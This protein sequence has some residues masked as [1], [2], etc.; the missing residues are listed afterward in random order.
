MDW[1]EAFAVVTGIPPAGAQYANLSRQPQLFWQGPFDPSVA[2][3][4]ALPTMM[5][6][7]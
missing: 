1:L 3:D 6:Q 5:Q 2:S 4:Q 7:R